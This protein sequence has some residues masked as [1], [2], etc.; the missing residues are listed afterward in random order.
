MAGAR[1]HIC[2]HMPMIHDVRQKDLLSGVE[3]NRQKQTDLLRLFL[4]TMTWHDAIV[5]SGTREPISYLNIY[6]SATFNFSA[7]A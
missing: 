4:L 6:Y 3:Q 5:K 1:I 7:N 2:F